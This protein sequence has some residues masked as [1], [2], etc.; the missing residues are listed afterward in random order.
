MEAARESFERAEKNVEI[1]TQQVSFP[2]SASKSMIR[3][4]SSRHRPLCHPFQSHTTAR[5]LIRSLPL[6][7]LVQL[8]ALLQRHTDLH[9]DQFATLL[10]QKESPFNKAFASA[11]AEMQTQDQL[12]MHEKSMTQIVTED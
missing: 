12:V 7:V 1:Y 9:L 3:C 5:L 2:S 10:V 8:H 6:C 4:C 11:H